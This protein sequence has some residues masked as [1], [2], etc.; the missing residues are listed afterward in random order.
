MFVNDKARERR[1]HA[2]IHRRPIPERGLVVSD[3]CKPIPDK[4]EPRGWNTFV[5]QPRAAVIPV[6]R[7]F[8]ANAPEDSE[9]RAVVR[10]RRV[11]YDSKTINEVLGM[12]TVDDSVFQAWMWDPDYELIVRTLCYRG[13]TWKQP[14]TYNVFLEKILKVDEACWYAF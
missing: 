11:S 1:E 13:S 3:F 12:V 10:R 14:S 6:L 8:Y 5:A 2:K 9:S 4:V 7:E